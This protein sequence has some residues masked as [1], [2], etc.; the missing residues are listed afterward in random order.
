MNRVEDL[1]ELHYALS[2]LVEYCDEQE[3]KSKACDECALKNLNI[4]D[5]NHNLSRLNINN[6]DVPKFYF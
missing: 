6:P 3:R 1:R 4:C 2:I 5:R